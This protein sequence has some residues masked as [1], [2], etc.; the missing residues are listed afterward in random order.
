MTTMM[1]SAR[2][3]ELR[4]MLRNSSCWPQ[5]RLPLTSARRDQ[6]ANEWHQQQRG[7]SP[8]VAVRRVIPPSRLKT[9]CRSHEGDPRTS[10]GG[11]PGVP[12]DRRQPNVERPRTTTSSMRGRLGARSDALSSRGDALLFE[13]QKE[14]ARRLISRTVR[15]CLSKRRDDS[16]ME[17]ASPL[18]SR[19]K[20]RARARGAG[21]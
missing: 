1:P 20:L 8:E 21:R 5:D 6:D 17:R 9:A 11:R 4:Q 13:F 15:R 16:G 18:E 10:R 12:P 19:T 7:P 3:Q 2:A 14:D